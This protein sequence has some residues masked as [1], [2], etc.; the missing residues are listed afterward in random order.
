[1]EKPQSW[2]ALV[3]TLTP[4]LHQSLKNAVE[5][6]RWPNGDKLTPAQL[7]HSLQAI[8]AYDQLYLPQEQRTAFID[9]EG[10]KKSHCDD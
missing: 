3:A 1:M 7:E 5:T 2:R 8:I 6:G 4:E 10:L 9:R